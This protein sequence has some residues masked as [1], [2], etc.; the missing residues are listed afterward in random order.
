M[1]HMLQHIKADDHIKLSYPNILNRADDAD[2]LFIHRKNLL[3]KLHTFFGN[4]II[5]DPMTRGSQIG[6]IETKPISKAQNIQ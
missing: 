5:S 1:L 3:R 2:L 4:F 6:A